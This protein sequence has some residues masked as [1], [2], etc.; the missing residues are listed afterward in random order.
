MIEVITGSQV[1]AEFGRNRSVNG[2]GDVEQTDGRTNPNYSMISNRAGFRI[3]ISVEEV[4]LEIYGIQFSGLF[5]GIHISKWLGFRIQIS[6][7]WDSGFKL[8]LPG[9]L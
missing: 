8:C 7:G 9:L 3:Q 2:K 4:T 5:S 1:P 6:N